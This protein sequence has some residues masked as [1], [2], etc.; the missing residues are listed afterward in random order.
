M[1]TNKCN[2]SAAFRSRIFR[3]T[4]KD[5]LRKDS[6]LA[7]FTIQMRV[8][9]Y[10]MVCLFTGSWNYALASVSSYKKSDNL[11]TSASK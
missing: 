9:H 5:H 3:N 10:T 7:D 2:S 1:N 4:T 11:I 8:I 6:R